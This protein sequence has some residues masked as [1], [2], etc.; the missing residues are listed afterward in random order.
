MFKPEF[1]IAL[2]DVSGK[3]HIYLVF[4]NPDAVEGQILVQMNSLEFKSKTAVIQ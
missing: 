2:N 4:K 1:Q 3:H